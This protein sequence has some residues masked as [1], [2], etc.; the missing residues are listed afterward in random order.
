[1]DRRKFVTGITALGCSSA[2]TPLVTPV[3]FATAPWD[4]RLVVILL[5]GA[6]DGLDIVQP[7]GDPTLE[8]VRPGFDIGP[9]KGARDL[10][11]FYALHNNLSGLM[12]LWFDGELAFAHAVST[13]YRNK[14][15]H[16]DGQDLLEAGTGDVNFGGVSDGWL[17]RLLQG[18]PGV[19][20]RTAF[21][22][23]QEQMI[24]LSGDAQTAGWSPNA[25]LDLSPQARLL[26]GKIY[27]NDPVFHASASV[28]ME[29]AE[30]G[31]ALE[32]DATGEGAMSMQDMVDAA[33]STR[34][35]SAA[36]VLARFTAERLKE[37]TRIASFSISGWDTHLNQA[38]GIKR[39]SSEL[40]TAI[41]TLK[42]ELGP[43]WR[44]T[45]VLAMTEFG[46]TIHVNGSRGT[47]HGTG[48]AM[49]MAGGA[50]KGQKVY[51]RW[52]GLAE[53]DL[54][55]RRD[56]MSTEDVR[57]YAASAIQGLFGIDQATLERR[58]FPKLD[59]SNAPGIIL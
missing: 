38:N 20:A 29:L 45:A 6:M 1:M 3:S 11:G 37:E 4:N 40:E 30:A 57:S 10:D 22:V 48:G 55:D 43:I 33:N 12:P 44:K 26:L 24:I 49:L 14:R 52:P 41:L 31:V 53:V 7:Y 36:K 50:I 58:V 42:A 17:N 16:F 25:R 32:S 59:M 51:G 19:H 34:K 21:A 27:E 35:A 13:P 9:K 47:D 46:R 28:A 8:R 23:G 5:R 54:F 15:S 39:A 18:Q 2:A 56:L